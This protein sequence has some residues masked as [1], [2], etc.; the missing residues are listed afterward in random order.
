MKNTYEILGET[1]VFDDGRDGD[2]LP[3][4]KLSEILEELE[5]VCN[6][7][8]EE[9]DGR[10]YEYLDWEEETQ[11]FGTINRNGW[12]QIEMYQLEEAIENLTS[13]TK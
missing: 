9:R 4:F 12:V 2:D 13:K 7:I 1:L 10:I 8:V 11:Y 6:N 5:S 3:E